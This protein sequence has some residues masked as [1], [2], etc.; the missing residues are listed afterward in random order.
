MTSGTESA[1]MPNMDVV[2]ETLKGQLR[3][4]LGQVVVTA[5]IPGACAALRLGGG[6]VCVA[7][8]SRASDD[9]RPMPEQTRFDLGCLGKGLLCAVALRLSESG[10]LDLDA[11]IGHYLTEIAGTPNG[12]RVAVRHL[13]SQTP[14]YAGIFFLDDEVAQ[15]GWSD[16]VDHVR[17][18]PQLFVPGTV[19]DYEQSAAA[20]LA[21]T[22]TRVTRRPSAA[23]I[24]EMILGPLCGPPTADE[25]DL[26]AVP[27]VRDTDAENYL[28]KVTSRYSLSELWRTSITDRALSI[29]KIARL[30]E[31]FM[32]GSAP[33]SATGTATLSSGITRRLAERAVSIPQVVMGQR[34]VRNRAIGYGFGLEEFA[35][36][37]F[38]RD[39]TGDGDV[40]AM[41]FCPTAELAFAVA[42]NASATAV[43]WKVVD[44]ILQGFG[45]VT[46][47]AQPAP[48]GIELRELSGR[49]V[50]SRG[51]DGSVVT[52]GNAL[53]VSGNLGK[54]RY[55]LSASLKEDGC[56]VVQSKNRGGLTFFR[57]P[58][59]GTPCLM[60]NSL[61]LKKVSDEL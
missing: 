4:F 28:K 34:T 30:A 57:D 6:E 48:I 49:Y 54:K 53:T 26:R 12:D 9:S 2:L 17:A 13:M 55:E 5:E 8:G 42:F 19:Y 41:R 14:G 56:L 24:E 32:S 40:V 46:P 47:S 58:V 25:G 27:H 1:A 45:L 43:R 38:G 59:A 22:V 52:N 39:G 35:N 60:L 44:A 23:V 50:G 61:A 16:L 15:F 31:L 18:A 37:V 36:N 29:D 3:S 10:E 51:V 21:E 20:L 7:V 33:P 11:P